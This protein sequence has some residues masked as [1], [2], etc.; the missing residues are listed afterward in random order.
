MAYLLDSDTLISAKN[1][2]YRFSFCPAFWDWI[3]KSNSGGL[4][5][6]IEAIEIE[7]KRGNDNLAAWVR[8]QASRIFLK[9]DTNV[10]N[11]AA[12]VSAWVSAQTQFTPAARNEFFAAADYWL[13]AHG[14]AY[15][16]TVVTRERPDP[17][18]RR[19]VKIPDV[20]NALGIAWSSPFAMLEK[21][22][23]Q[24]RLSP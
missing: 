14:L 18:S 15:G 22:S 5:F 12:L 9:P 16:Y 10:T 23:A 3:L 1:D 20:C 6:S 21:E 17:N 8:G 24:F 11:A 7:L 19:K 2:W 4:V 13:C